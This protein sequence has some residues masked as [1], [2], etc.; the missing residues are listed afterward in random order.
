M[1]P[2]LLRALW[3][4]YELAQQNIDDFET[5]GDSELEEMLAQNEKDLEMVLAFIRGDQKEKQNY[6]SREKELLLM[7]DSILSLIN[8]DKD[9]SFFIREEGAETLNDSHTLVDRTSALRRR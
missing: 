9:G 1:T 8:E 5:D 2:E 4:V 6:K 3:A 7:L